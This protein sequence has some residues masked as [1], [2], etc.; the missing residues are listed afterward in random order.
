MN[1]EVTVESRAVRDML[2]GLESQAP[3]AMSLALNNTANDVQAA[4]RKGVQSRFTLRRPDF[5]LNTVKIAKDERATKAK[6]EVTVH[7]DP[8]R[9]ILA[10]FEEGGEKRPREGTHLAIPVAIKRNKNDIIPR[11]RY[12]RPLLQSK[13]GLAGRVFATAVGIMKTVGRGARASTSVLYLFRTSVRL[14]AKLRLV[15]TSNETVDKV[16]KTRAI[17]AVD[18]AIA[19]M[20]R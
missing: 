10:K 14:P 4:I 12:P 3:F 7:I 2:K 19:T 18:R 13:A 5:I 16:W 1:V 9:N 15:Q 20:R 11:A 17:E 8:T 6:Q